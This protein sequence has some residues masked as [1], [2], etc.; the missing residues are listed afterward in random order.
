MIYIWILLV[1]SALAGGYLLWHGV[2]NGFVRG[3]IGG[4]WEEPDGW[5]GTDAKYVGLWEACL[6]AVGECV[7]LGML[8]H[9]LE[10][11]GASI[12]WTSTA[13]WFIGY[14]GML[15]Y[16]LSG[17]VALAFA[18][19]SG[20]VRWALIGGI[21]VVTASWGLVMYSRI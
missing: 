21:S 19:H 1:G 2:V 11:G 16:F 13:V 18:R 3:H 17:V 12:E 6:G 10:G 8:V 20:S 15:C 5:S 4:G 7:A 14:P 9:I